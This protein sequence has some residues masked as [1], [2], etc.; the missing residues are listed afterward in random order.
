MALLNFKNSLL[1][2]LLL[3]QLG[4][5][6]AFS[7]NNYPSYQLIDGSSEKNQQTQRRLEILNYAAALRDR[8]RDEL[9][10]VLTDNYINQLAFEET[11]YNYAVYDLTRVAYQ[12][13][14]DPLN[15]AETITAYE[16]AILITILHHFV[17][18][19]LLEGDLV[20]LMFLTEAAIGA[21]ED[22]PLTTEQAENIAVWLQLIEDIISRLIAV[23]SSKNLTLLSGN[24][25]QGGD[26]SHDHRALWLRGGP[27]L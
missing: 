9:G 8:M 3:C 14:I 17:E 19:P 11:E 22:E 4:L 26:N 16:C 20:L 6:P 13:F 21:A 5:A 18:M 10:V 27:S 15:T 2:A 24:S 7:S 1:F 25:Q 12:Q 23:K